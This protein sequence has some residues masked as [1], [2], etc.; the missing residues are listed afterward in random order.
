MFKNQGNVSVALDAIG[1]QLSVNLGDEL[2]LDGRFQMTFT[3][4]SNRN[5][6]D[7]A[8]SKE[9]RIQYAIQ[10]A[11][12]SMIDGKGELY[13]VEAQLYVKFKQGFSN[14]MRN[15][16]DPTTAEYEL[17]TALGGNTVGVLAIAFSMKRE[18]ARASQTKCAIGLTPLP[19]NMN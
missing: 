7:R 10:K 16:A 15:R 17:M 8:A 12:A 5:F 13:K 3:V 4:A 11:K 18:K 1:K 19:R 14:E 6:I 2:G 9:A